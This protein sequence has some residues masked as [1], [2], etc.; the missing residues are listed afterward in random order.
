MINVRIRGFF[1]EFH[2]DRG[3]FEA[4][5]SR[6]I[7]HGLGEIIVFCL[8]AASV[9]PSASPSVSVFFNWHIGRLVCFC[10][11]LFL[12]CV[13]SCSCGPRCPNKHCGRCW[14]A[15]N[16][17]QQHNPEYVHTETH[18]MARMTKKRAAHKLF[19]K[20]KNSQR[21]AAHTCRIKK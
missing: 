3:G 10:C 19:G 1:S 2:G 6:A 20:H 14:E 5:S 17:Q 4:V 12:K 7:S 21:K 11:L 15:T 13:C 9:S 18:V 8:G 16:T